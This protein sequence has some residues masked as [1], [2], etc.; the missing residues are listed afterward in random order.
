MPLKL[1]DNLRA[2]RAAVHK[3]KRFDQHTGAQAERQLT[4]HLLHNQKGVP[5]IRGAQRTEG[6]RW[7]SN[8]IAGL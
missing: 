2:S 1:F 7:L 8:A 6:L 3:A 5:L 4:A